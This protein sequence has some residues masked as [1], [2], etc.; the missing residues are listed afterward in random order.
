[1]VNMDADKNNRLTITCPGCKTNMTY[2]LE[3]AL[4]WHINETIV[5]EIK[6][7]IRQQAFRIGCYCCLLG[8][9]IVAAVIFR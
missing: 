9:L 4:Y 6:K 1:M 8:I 5:Q 2:R 7:E 3:S